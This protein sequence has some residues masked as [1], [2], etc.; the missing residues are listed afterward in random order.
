VAD[1]SP[2]P[3]RCAIRSPARSRSVAHSRTRRGWSSP[4]RIPIPIER[5]GVQRGCPLRP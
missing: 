1:S 2:K 3:S 5:G 4:R